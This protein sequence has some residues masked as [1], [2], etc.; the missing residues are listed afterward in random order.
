ME[1]GCWIGIDVSKLRLDYCRG[2]AGTPA[3]V[4]NTPAGHRRLLRVLRKHA[5]AGIVLEST[6][7]YHLA[8]VETLQDAGLPV[9]V[10][11]PQLVKWYRASYGEKAKTDPADA[12]LLAAF[13]EARCPRPARVPTANERVPREL[14]A[15]RDDLVALIG[16]EKNRRGVARDARVRRH[17]EAAITDA[18]RQRTAIEQEIDALIASDPALTARRARL[19]TVPGVGWV[20]SVVLLAYLPELGELDRRQIAALAGLAPYADDSGARQGTRHCRGGR[21]PVRRAMYLAALTCAT[22]ARVPQTVYRDQYAALAPT[23]GAKRALVAIARRMLVLLNAMV[24]DGLTW[25]ET[26][27]AQG[28]HPRPGT[29]P[30]LAAA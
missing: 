10:V 18:T 27:I 6:G 25:E 28:R 14:V 12:R 8:L 24:R 4:P 15:R 2:A 26:E 21:A 1:A 30:E 3:Q 9:S 17:I 13:G 20:T 19:R 16:A 29:R 23:K 7:A 22:N 5:F 11:T